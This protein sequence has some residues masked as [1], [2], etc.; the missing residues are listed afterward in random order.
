MLSVLFIAYI[1][2]IYSGG[3]HFGGFRFYQPTAPL[4]ILLLILLINKIFIVNRNL[5]LVLIVLFQLVF[6]FNNNI[7]NLINRNSTI[8]SEFEIA[9][10]GKLRSEKLYNF[11][12]INSKLPSQGIIAAGG[13]NYYEGVSIDLV[14]LNNVEMAHS[15][16]DVTKKEIKNHFS[17]NKEI[18]Y[19]QLPDI[20]WICGDFLN[21]ED[22]R[23]PKVRDWE[24][25]II[26][27]VHLEKRFNDIYSRYEIVNLKN[28]NYLLRAYLKDNFVE[29]LNIKYYTWKKLD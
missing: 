29:N 22:K 6:S 2:P 25:N 4:S 26:K 18:F 24:G 12:K 11:F 14:G 16:K 27:N 3:D 5:Y 7:K 23:I 9:L 1:F 8:K 10:D 15:K 17:F 28:R 19:K 20:L 21:F 13:A